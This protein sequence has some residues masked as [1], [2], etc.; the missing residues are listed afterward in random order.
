MSMISM[1]ESVWL[2][3]GSIVNYPYIKFLAVGR[4]R[5]GGGGGWGWGSICC[6]ACW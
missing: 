3:M 5:G 1:L 6:K 4:Q 2:R